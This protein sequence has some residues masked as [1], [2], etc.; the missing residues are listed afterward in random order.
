MSRYTVE[1]TN[2][3]ATDAQGTIGYD[4]PLRTF[5]LQGF[6]HPETDECA[7]WLGAFLDEYATLESII[8]T[9]RAAGYEVRGLTQKM[10]ITMIKESGKPTPPSLGERLG[11][12]R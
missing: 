4:P 12:V 1:I 11:I 8:E 2:G 6:P 5:F 9:A 10:M 7:L 3:T